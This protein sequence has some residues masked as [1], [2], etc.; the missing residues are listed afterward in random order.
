MIS[1]LMYIFKSSCA[2]SNYLVKKKIESRSSKILYETNEIWCKYALRVTDFQVDTCIC[3]II[4]RCMWKREFQVQF[5]FSPS[6]WEQ[7]MM[8]VN[9][10]QAGCRQLG[11]YIWWLEYWGLWIL[12]LH[13]LWVEIWTLQKTGDGIESGLPSRLYC[14]IR[15]MKLLC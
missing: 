8:A 15:K 5:H 12:D 11:C 7:G 1:L 13:I 6:W 9:V 4:I 14:G 3:R 10:V 2:F